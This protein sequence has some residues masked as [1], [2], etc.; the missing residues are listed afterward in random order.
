MDIISTE[1]LT[2]YYGKTKGI[3]NLSLNVQAGEVFGFVG[4]NGSGKSTT[5]RTLLALIHKT[6]GKAKI[7][8]LDTEKDNTEILKRVG[9]LP[10]EVF[11]YDRMS[12][13]ELLNYSASFYPQDC[14][15]RIKELAQTL[16]V[17]LDQKIEDMSLGNKKKVGI[18]QG[19][20]HKPE[21]I[22]LD[23]PTSGLDPLMQKVFFDLI[24]EENKKGATIFF[25]SHILSEVQRLCDRV[26]IIKNGS[27]VKIQKME[28]LKHNQ[29]K[30][31]ELVINEGRFNKELIGITDY[32]E[33]G[34]EVSF[35]YQGDLNNLVN[36]LNELKLINLEISEPS[37]EEV[38][39]HYYDKD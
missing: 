20:L 32:Q 26:A 15:K 18:I 21:L 5:I 16:E 25:S 29:V 1:N 24:K 4:P 37:L 2:K 27:I 12:A 28:D 19:L 6:S 39:L 9:Y 22:I 17:N 8:G 31:V 13:K 10:S 35:L 34:N 14:S 3:E 7:F 30:K 33:K 36:R 11:Y 38:F 23:E